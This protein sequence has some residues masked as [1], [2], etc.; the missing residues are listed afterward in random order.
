MS[1]SCI[2]VNS[3]NESLNM[4]LKNNEILIDLT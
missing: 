1:D 2:T 3:Y 4:V